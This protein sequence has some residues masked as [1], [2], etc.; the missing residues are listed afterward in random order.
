MP[1]TLRT[2][3]SSDNPDPEQVGDGSEQDP[4]QDAGS[5]LDSIL[6]EIG[7]SGTQGADVTVIV[8][9][10]DPSSTARHGF[11][12][13]GRY[14][15]AGF[16]PFMLPRQFGPGRFRI[17]FSR[18]GKIFKNVQSA[19]LLPVALAPELSGDAPQ[20]ELRESRKFEREL[21][22]TV[23][24]GVVGR[25]GSA[26]GG[27]SF[28]EMLSAFKAG[29]EMNNGPAVASPSTPLDVIREAILLGKGL[30]QPSGLSGVSDDDEPRRGKKESLLD[31]FAPRVFDLIE[32][33]MQNQPTREALPHPA[34]D[35]NA[36]HAVTE[37][38]TVTDST[39]V[40]LVREL[41]PQI[42]SEAKAKHDAAT[43]GA[44]VAERCPEEYVDHLAQFAGAT[45]DERQAF[46]AQHTPE[47]LAYSGWLNDAC[48]GVMEVLSPDDDPGPGDGGDDAAA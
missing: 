24:S 15:A 21:L 30:S 7:A 13:C 14:T 47:L 8:A 6:S 3:H 29:R 5:E 1:P 19:F 22:M 40:T 43:W 39:L 2:A 11:A 28:T 27:A 35:V 12:M 34:G 4:D 26:S 25:G 17:Q 23:L 37:D 46:I 45:N 36:L 44:Y 32:R 9:K 18:K 16:D 38:P 48:S 42:I 10:H 20:N 31:R 33:A 41:V